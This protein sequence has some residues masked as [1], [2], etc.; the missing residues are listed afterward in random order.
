MDA[1]CCSQA[2]DPAPGGAPWPL[3]HPL[4]I[5]AALNPVHLHWCSC[6]LGTLV[7]ATQ[8]LVDWDLLVGEAVNTHAEGQYPGLVLRAPKRQIV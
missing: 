5:P 6:H 3:R 7:I 1:Q 2:T 4:L 8:S